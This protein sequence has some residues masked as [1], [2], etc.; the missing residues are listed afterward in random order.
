MSHDHPTHAGGCREVFAQLSAY[1]DGELTPDVRRELE[2]HLCN[3]A[4]CVEFVNSLRRTVDLC[5]KFEPSSSPGPMTAE[6]KDQLLAAC[7]R[8]L[9]ARRGSP[10]L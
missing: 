7:R 8:M 10:S 3:C 9:A 6:A 1:I 2:E 5:H 4:P